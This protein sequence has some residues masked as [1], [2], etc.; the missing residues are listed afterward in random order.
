[1][2]KTIF[3]SMVAASIS[4]FLVHSQLLE[5]Q[6]KW[7]QGRS[8]FLTALLDCS[9]C[10]GHWVVAAL[11]LGACI[12]VPRLSS[13]LLITRLYQICLFLLAPLCIWGGDA[14][15][16]GLSRFLKSAMSSLMPKRRPASPSN[17]STNSS[18]YVIFF[19]VA[20]L[21]PY[22]LLNS[23]FIFEIA[24]LK[25]YSG[26]PAS[27]ALSGDKIDWQIFSEEEAEA[28][29]YL[30][31]AAGSGKWV[32]ADGFG[33]QLVCERLDKKWVR[34]IPASGE[35]PPNAYLFFR[36][37]NLDKQEIAV[38]VQRGVQMRIGH[39]RLD[40]VPQL[41]ENKDLIYSNAGAHVLRS[42]I[43]D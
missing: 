37:R 23:G 4:F 7:I 17:P 18:A 2:I 22:F 12:V 6:R 27:M 24:N 3:L 16:Q 28:T 35:V 38:F 5:K 42:R 41:L 32:Y 26:A 20:I 10:L 13:N 29:K 19:A 8:D 9:Y 33:V 40:D 30:A 31:R 36:T 21:I 15:W 43:I 39:V 1:M 34:S 25:P 11:I 14:I